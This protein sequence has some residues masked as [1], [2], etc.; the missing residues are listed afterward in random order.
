MSRVGQ[1][2][3]RHASPSTSSCI[4]EPRSNMSS[5]DVGPPSTTH[6]PNIPSSAFVAYPVGS[7]VHYPEDAHYSP[8]FLDGGMQI[9]VLPADALRRSTELQ[10]FSDSPPLL[11]PS[12]MPTVGY[13]SAET[14]YPLPSSIHAQRPRRDSPTRSFMEH[15]REGSYYAMPAPQ[16]FGAMFNS[17]SAHTTSLPFASPLSSAEMGMDSEYVLCSIYVHVKLL[18]S[19]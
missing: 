12:N 10:S 11:P 9:P 6:S 3:S 1:D 8:H 5:P 2:T 18:I 17:A 13:M 14:T 16:D 15:S 19:L 7:D 4:S